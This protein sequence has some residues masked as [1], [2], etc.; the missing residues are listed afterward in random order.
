[1]FSQGAEQAAHQ[2]ATAIMGTFLISFFQAAR[3]RKTTLDFVA[4][5]TSPSA[6]C[7]S[8]SH[9]TVLAEQDPARSH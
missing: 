3:A 9:T 8:S 7:G 1:M 2:K 6:K 4:G 5:S